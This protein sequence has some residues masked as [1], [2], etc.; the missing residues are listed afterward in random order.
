MELMPRGRHHWLTRLYPAAWRDRYG[1]ELDALIEDEGGGWSAIANIVA[2]A[3]IEHLRPSIVGARTMTY[4]GNVTALVR[5]PSG[6]IPI[7]MSAAALAVVLTA[8]AMVGA[9][10]EPDEGAAAHM[11]QILIAG[12]LPFLAWFA[13]HWLRRDFRSALSVML[14]QGAAIAVALFPVWYFG[15]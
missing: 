4:P 3:L 2:N 10:H 13:F 8:V 12:Q 15:L 11:F 5:K 14:L 7:I 6:M 9:R 1:D